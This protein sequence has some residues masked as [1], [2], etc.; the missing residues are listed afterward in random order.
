MANDAS[1]WGLEAA[2]RG[3]RH[4]ALALLAEVRA[5][6]AR[7]ADASDADALHDFR[8]A[9][10]RLRSWFRML[11]SDLEG[12]V[13]P[14]AARVLATVA[15]T[16]NAGR[17]AEVLLG[18]LRETID[19]LAPR[20]RTAARWLMRQ[21]QEIQADASR[22]LHEELQQSFDATIQRLDRR[23]RRY[24]TMVYL[25]DGPREAT[26]SQRVAERVRSQG[27]RLAADLARIADVDADTDIHRARIEGK[28]LR[29]LLEPLRPLH[30]SIGGIVTRLKS[31]QDILG[32]VH[33]AH[34]W[35]EALHQTLQRAADRQGR[36]LRRR[37]TGAERTRRG[38]ALP[39]M[40]ALMALADAMH[41][42]AASEFAVFTRDWTGDPASAFFAELELTATALADADG[43]PL[44]IE[45]KYLLSG[46]PPAM[47]RG[48]VAELLQGY[49]P[50]ERIIERVRRTSRGRRSTFARTIKFGSG[51]VRT[52][53][54][55]P[56]TRRV[57]DALWPLTKG[58][59]VEKRRHAIREGPLTWEIDVFTDRDLVLA[60]VELADQRDVVRFPEWLAPYVERDVT[61]ESAYV[62][63]VL[64]K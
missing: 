60:E 31:L 8:V 32:A 5:T 14:K 2:P 23:L 58:K 36:V 45:R 1:A 26:L 12:S 64:A 19:R 37:A 57:F 46:V 10:R 53:I 48:T 63:F 39:P 51:I 28:R 13:P 29:Y 50:G 40:S 18:W 17:D 55:E 44:E 34:V 24:S 56:T 21:Q 9:V 35:G 49:L 54:E 43:A 11:A 59:R 6:S 4:V 33:D 41:A 7:L 30:P 27:G 52:E 20:H 38:A 42:H 16:S 22:E 3:A 25:D 47:P 15:S 62:N 61:D